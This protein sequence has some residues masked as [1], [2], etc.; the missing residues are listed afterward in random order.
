MVLHDRT[1]AVG[2]ALT[3]RPNQRLLMVPSLLPKLDIGRRVETTIDGQIGQQIHHEIDDKAQHWIAGVFREN[4]VK[5]EGSHVLRAFFLKIARRR[6]IFGNVRVQLLQYMVWQ[7]ACQ[8]GGQFR[9]EYQAKL[10]DIAN[11]QVLEIKVISQQSLGA[12]AAYLMYETAPPGARTG[13]DQPLCLKD[14]HRLANGAL[15]HAKPV[16]QFGLSRETIARLQTLFD[17]PILDR[18]GDLNRSA[19]LCVSLR[20]GGDR[21]QV[22]LLPSVSSPALGSGRC[23]LRADNDRQRRNRAAGSAGREVRSPF[24]RAPSGGAPRLALSLQEAWYRDDAGLQRCVRLCRFRPPH[25]NTAR[26]SCHSRLR[27]QQDHG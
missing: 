15:G 12:L 2:V 14:A 10:I 9:L 8:G 24:A 1:G 11:G 25:R 6:G 19:E 4:G 23:P 5:P 18:L 13:F 21:R 17:H 20:A 16:Y 7:S 27:Q 22:G 3:Q 26:L